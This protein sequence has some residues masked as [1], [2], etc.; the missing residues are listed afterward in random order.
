MFSHFFFVSPVSL[1]YLFFFLFFLSL[2]S[3]I[4]HTLSYSYLTASRRPYIS[5]FFYPRY[6][7]PPPHFSL[8]RVSTPS[9]PF[10]F[11]FLP[12]ISISISRR[13]HL[14]FFACLSSCMYV[15]DRLRATQCLRL[16]YSTLPDVCSYI[17][18]IWFSR[19]GYLFLWVDGQRVAC[20]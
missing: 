14:I 3:L 8:V 11:P 5:C 13:S 17:H 20:K 18:E 19:L 15:Y 4:V 10:Q 2:L 6:P 16:P 1:L 7:L 12:P 9:S